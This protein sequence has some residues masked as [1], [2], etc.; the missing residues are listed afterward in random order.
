MS[1]YF[2]FYMLCYV[3]LCY[4]ML[5]YVMLCFF[6]IVSVVT[7]VSSYGQQKLDFWPFF[8][9]ESRPYRLNRT[10]LFYSSYLKRT[11]L[12]Q[13]RLAFKRMRQKQLLS[14]GSDNVSSFVASVSNTD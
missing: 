6:A 10:K 9:G 5:C 3:M 4:V 14:R 7:V 8:S 12:P 2:F 1:M 11:F 13:V